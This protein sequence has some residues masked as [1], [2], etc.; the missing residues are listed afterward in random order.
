M[1]GHRH[2]CVS[3]S[4]PSVQQHCTDTWR[5]AASLMAP[6]ASA[7]APCSTSHQ[8]LTA[9]PLTGR[10]H[11]HSSSSLIYTASLGQGDRARLGWHESCLSQTGNKG[12]KK[13]KPWEG[14]MGRQK[15]GPGAGVGAGQEAL[16]TERPINFLIFALG[17]GPN[18][19]ALC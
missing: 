14:E 2:F 1:P 6:I 7:F 9:V 17:P 15:G 19:P 13:T 4:V 16:P 12:E 11:S 5:S 18:S 3:P 8:V 10:G